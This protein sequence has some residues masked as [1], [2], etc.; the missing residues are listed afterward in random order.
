MRAIN[1]IPPEEQRGRGPARGGALSYLVVGV[2]V[3]VLVGVTALV[4]T[5]KQISDREAE[6]TEL[7]Q[8]RDAVQARAE[9][10]QAFADFRAMQQARTATVTSLAQSRFDWERVIRELALV[11]PDDAWLVSLRA[12]VSP[13]VQPEGGTSVTGRES[14]PGP[15]LEL[16]GCTVSQQAVG[17]FVAAL[18]DIDG[19][20]RVTAFKSEL[21]EPTAGGST[22]ETGAASEGPVTTDECR[23]RDFIVR[24]EI[25]VAFDEVPVPA[26]AITPSPTA[27][28]SG[29]T[30]PS[31]QSES[32][33][34][35][36]E[37]VQEGQEAANLVP[38]T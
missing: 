38:G 6:V 2:L 16:V 34:E 28:A 19:V 5:N 9:S 25:V 13:E 30:P 17:R 24:F 4:F 11:L 31:T 15:A 26:E 32:Q 21:P 18:R 7:E 1:L 8:R 23:T 35:V 10:L 12:S 37:G 29:E 20:T 27:P 3:A 33:A 14:V 36:Q 22:A